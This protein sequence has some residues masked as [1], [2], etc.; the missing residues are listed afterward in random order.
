MHNL[1]NGGSQGCYFL[2]ENEGQKNLT[3][4]IYRSGTS[5]SALQHI[6]EH[7]AEKLVTPWASC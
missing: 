5:L 7:L 4:E 1:A 6:Y 3:Q 2:N